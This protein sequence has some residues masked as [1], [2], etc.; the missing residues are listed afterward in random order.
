MA[1]TFAK[2]Q[3]IAGSLIFCLSY[4]ITLGGF[5]KAITCTRAGW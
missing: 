1:L 2:G 5:V 3:G 4:W